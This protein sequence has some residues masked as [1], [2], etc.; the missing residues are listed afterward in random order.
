MKKITIKKETV[1][2]IWNGVKTVAGCLALGALAMY[3]PR[4]PACSTSST[5][6]YFG[7][8]SYGDAVNAILSSSM[9]D[10]RKT[11]AITLLKR[12][13]DHD[14]YSAVISAVGSDMFDSR[15]VQ[16]IK[17]LSEK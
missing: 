2:R 11:E 14:Y 17:T 15:K 16:V 3:A 8:A 7:L 13:G 5:N 1:D 10:S 6:N 4:V 12:D 9:F